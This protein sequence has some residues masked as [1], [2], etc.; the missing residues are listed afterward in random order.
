MSLEFPFE[1]RSQGQ[2]T[3]STKKHS[4]KTTTVTFPTQPKRIENPS[5]NSDG[6]HKNK[7]K[8]N[9]GQQKLPL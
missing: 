5:I 7:T 9:P 6:K 1:W 2:G 8:S 4:E 3:D